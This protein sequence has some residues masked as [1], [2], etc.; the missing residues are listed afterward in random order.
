M[1]TKARITVTVPKELLEVVEADVAAG[2]AA[3]VSAWVSEAMEAK[4]RSKAVGELLDEMDD[5]FGRPVTDEE[6]AWAHKRL[7][8][9]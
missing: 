3:S 8:L 4:S 5:H 7:G 1:R 2:R 6:R 9:S